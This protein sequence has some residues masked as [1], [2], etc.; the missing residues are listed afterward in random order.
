MPFGW[1]ANPNIPGVRGTLWG[2]YKSPMPFGWGANP[3]GS[4]I[5]ARSL[6]V[7]LG[8]QCLSAGGLIQTFRQ[9]LYC[10]E[11]VHAVTNAFRLGG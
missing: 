7:A 11:R 5:K 10:C 1:G 2:A 3:N 4:D 6:T 8:H 9:K